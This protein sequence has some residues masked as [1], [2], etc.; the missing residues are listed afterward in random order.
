M[1]Y[2]VDIN[3]DLGE[4][5]GAYQIGNDFEIMKW[6]SSANIA[7]GYHAGDHNIM[8][9]SVQMAKARNIEI[10]AHPGL[11]DL[12]GFGRR[13]IQINPKEVYNLMIY[14]IGAM[15]AFANIHQACL[16]HVKPHGALYNMANKDKAIAEAIVNAIYDLNPHLILYS[17]SGS[18]LTKIG[19]AAGLKVAEEVFA[20][21]TYKSDGTLT[22][23]TEDNAMITVPEEAVNRVIRMI[24][25][26]KVKTIDGFDININVD[27]ICV[28]GDGDKS[29]EFVQLLHNRLLEDNIQIRPINQKLND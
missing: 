24:K 18:I 16:N 14:Q 22:P 6:I 13:Y 15:Q 8:Y 23:R 7:C 21:R 25:E 19:K 11:Q 27:T 1:K 10:G 20:D 5:F 26:G 2:Q 17:L 9:Q 12:I 3:S 29:L 28:H 4:S